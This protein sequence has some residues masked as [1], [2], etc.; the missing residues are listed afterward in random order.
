MEAKMK[1]IFLLLLIL[2]VALTAVCYF[3][4][5][6]EKPKEKIPGYMIETVCKDNGQNIGFTYTDDY[7]E[8]RYLSS[9]YDVI[10][11]DPQYHMQIN[12]S[13]PHDLKGRMTIGAFRELQSCDEIENDFEKYYKLVV[14]LINLYNDKP[15][16]EEQIDAFFK[17]KTNIVKENCPMK[18]EG[19]FYV[20][21]KQAEISEGCWIEYEISAFLNEEGDGPAE[22]Y[23]FEE[24]WT[25]E[26]YD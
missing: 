20:I 4:K 21:A 24:D 19:F 1:K 6:Y 22:E 25:I 9:I 16:T 15:L 12:I 2:L 10:L 13:T 18:D 7:G 11:D 14:D 5:V 17:D 26:C 23:G 3:G 8:K